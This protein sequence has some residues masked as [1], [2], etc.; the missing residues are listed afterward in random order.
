MNEYITLEEV[1]R[2]WTIPGKNPP[3][4]A[5]IWHRRRAGL[6]PQPKLVGRDNLYKREDVLRMRD[7]FLAG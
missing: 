2:I 3:S 7:E 4:T 1:K 6:I 5:T